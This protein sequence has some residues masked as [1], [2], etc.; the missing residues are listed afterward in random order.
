MKTLFDSVTQMES[1][2]D[3]Q[4]ERH[5]VLAGNIANIDTP[6]FVPFDLEQV[7]PEALSANALHRTDDGH[8][9]ATLAPGA[10]EHGRL[11]KD[12]TG[13]PAGADGNTVSLEGE[14]AKID[15][16]RVRYATTSQLVSRRLAL[17]RYASTGG[18]G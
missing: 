17:L 1:A 5:S 7:R 8:I 2:L 3:Y 11:L 12:A 9:L 13:G 18:N 16:N 14:L 4:R 6:G 10:A 15:S